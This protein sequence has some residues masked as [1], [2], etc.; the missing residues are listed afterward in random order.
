MSSAAPVARMEHAE[1][2]DH[3]QACCPAALLRPIRLA[4]GSTAG[5][6]LLS[7]ASEPSQLGEVLVVI[8]N[9]NLW[10]RNGWRTRGGRPIGNRDLWER[11]YALTRAQTVRCV[12]SR[13]YSGPDV[14][15]RARQLSART[16]QGAQYG[17]SATART[18]WP[19]GSA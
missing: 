10:H 18:V 2:A 7:A 5:L 9:Q 8:R 17:V 19:Q 14:T 13:D 11:L 12:L 6:T 15:G 16:A 3:D 1:P 4:P